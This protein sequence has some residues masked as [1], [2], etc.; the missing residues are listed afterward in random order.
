MINV[1]KIARAWVMLLKHEGDQLVRERINECRSCD[2]V[3]ISDFVI[4]RAGRV[5]EAKGLVCSVC[6]CP[7]VA[8]L[9]LPDE[10]CPHGKW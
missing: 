1:R 10:R 7:L 6:G 4:A 8:K 2:K 9:R 3:I 5:E